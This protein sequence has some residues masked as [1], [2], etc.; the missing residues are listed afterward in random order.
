VALYEDPLKRR[1]AA[2]VRAHTYD[3]TTVSLCARR[4]TCARHRCQPHKPLLTLHCSWPWPIVQ[5]WLVLCIRAAYFVPLPGFSAARSRAGVGNV[6]D[7]LMPTDLGDL[8]GAWHCV[9]ARA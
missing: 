5:V 9:H 7:L 3:A 6:V 2:T 1:I 4:G 8:T